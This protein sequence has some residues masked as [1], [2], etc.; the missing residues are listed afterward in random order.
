MT[1]HAENII[2]EELKDRPVKSEGWRSG[3]DRLAVMVTH[4]LRED[5]SPGKIIKLHA[6]GGRTKS[7]ECGGVR[8]NN[9]FFTHTEQRFDTGLRYRADG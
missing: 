2:S 5:F 8:L 6:Y 9:G 7:S 1:T 3:E 4:C